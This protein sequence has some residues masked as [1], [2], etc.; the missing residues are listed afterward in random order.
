MYL[1]AQDTYYVGSIKGV[2]HICQQT[3]IDTYTKVAFCKLYGRK[4]ALA[5]ADALNSEAIPL[6]DSRGIPLL[7]VLTDRGRVR[8]RNIFCVKRKIHNGTLSP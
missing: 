1:G 6:F 8:A 4:N 3:L 2:G 5:A 7:R